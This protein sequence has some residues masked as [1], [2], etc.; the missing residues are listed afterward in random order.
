MNC[1]AVA[2]LPEKIKAPLYASFGAEIVGCELVKK[3]GNSS[4]YRLTCDDNR[5]YALK[6]Y[7]PLSVDP[8]NRLKVEFDAL[9]FLRRQGETQVPA[10]VVALNHCNAGVYEW[11]DGEPLDVTSSQNPNQNIHNA[12]QFLQRLHQYTQQPGADRLPYASEACLSFSVVRQQLATRWKRL[13]QHAHSNA[14]LNRFLEDHYK[15]SE[16]KIIAYLDNTLAREGSIFDTE[17]PKE[18]L[19]L[20]PSDFGFHNAIKRADGNL[21]FVD[22]EYF[23]WD[24]PAK[25]IAD[26]LWHPGMK[27]ARELKQQF[28]TGA[29]QIYH[30][31][32]LKTRLEFLYPM[33]GLR[34][35]LIMLN[36]FLPDGRAK[37][38]HS[39]KLTEKHE[40]ELLAAQLHKAEQTLLKL[41]DSYKKFP[42]AI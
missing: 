33:C 1:S 40:S 38:Q 42:Y 12:L 14:A 39:G 5:Q 29:S 2:K 35:C 10:P 9:Q 3:G 4:V 24:D 28:V 25:L 13:H 31:S 23:G 15:P 34:W 19:T 21:I 32:K 27:L 17:T 6:N 7:P 26:F 20:S 16:Q 30:D 11:I 41:M 18:K 8:R 22:F 37:R 36:E